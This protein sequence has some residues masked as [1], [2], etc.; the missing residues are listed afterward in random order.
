MKKI[1]YVSSLAVDV[2]GVLAD[3]E[4]EFCH[5]FGKKNRHLA[6]LHQRYPEVDPEIINE[7]VESCMTY[8]NLIPIFGGN[9]LIRQ[10]QER[11]VY[12]VLLTSRPKSCMETT[13]E[14]LESYDIPYNEIVFSLNKG[15]FIGNFNMLHPNRRITALIDDMPAH[16]ENLPAGVVGVQWDA[17]WNKDSGWYPRMGYSGKKFQLEVIHEE[18]GT[19]RPFWENR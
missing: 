3:F 4:E 5:R 11:G 9:L 18:K 7:F 1:R 16:F 6:D 12:V 2:D 17:P 13:K 15:E 8:E 10:A 19:K 14:W